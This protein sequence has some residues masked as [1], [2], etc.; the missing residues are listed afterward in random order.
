MVKALSVTPMVQSMWASTIRTR[1]KA[2]ENLASLM[3]AYM[4]ALGRKISIMA[5]V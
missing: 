3:A 2:K 1:G 5:K 4:K